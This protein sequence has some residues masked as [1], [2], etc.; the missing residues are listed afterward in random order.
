MSTN[1]TSIKKRTEEGIIS[2]F[3][4]RFWKSIKGIFIQEEDEFWNDEKEPVKEPEVDYR[5]EEIK[6]SIKKIDKIE[7]FYQKTKINILKDVYDMTQIIH[8]VIVNNNIKY[9]KLS[10]FHMYY[11]DHYI[12]LIEKILKTQDE[13]I[14]YLKKMENNITSKMNDCDKKI[15]NIHSKINSFK[16]NESNKSKYESFIVKLIGSLFDNHVIS[17]A[18]KKLETRDTWSIKDKLKGETSEGLLDTSNINISGV[19]YD[20]PE[21]CNTLETKKVRFA[22][23][24]NHWINESIL[25]SIYENFKNL[26]YVDSFNHEPIFSFKNGEE[27]IY[28]IIYTKKNTIDIFNYYKSTKTNTDIIS[29]LENSITLIEIEKENLKKDREEY[30]NQQLFVNLDDKIADVLIKYYEKLKN[31]HEEIESNPHDTQLEIETL[32]NVIDIEMMKI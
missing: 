13:K 12:P 32:N 21:V 15:S 24:H 2:F 29:E 26:K 23:V 1:N 30:K 5:A 25:E 27:K 18:S 8:D 14:D 7:S 6:L 16:S 11:T 28:I 22:K 17:S 31:Y 9:Q 20:T 4:L 19:T 3:F 10:Q